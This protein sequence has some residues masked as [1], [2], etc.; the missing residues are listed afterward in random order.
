MLRVPDN[1]P[2]QMMLQSAWARA[3]GRCPGASG[4]F[5]SPL[6]ALLIQEC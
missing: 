2:P 6:Q 1:A 4:A 3:S 5:Q